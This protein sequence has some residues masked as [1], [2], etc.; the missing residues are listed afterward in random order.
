M[1]HEDTQKPTSRHKDNINKW[2]Y[3]VFCDI[4][5]RVLL[6]PRFDH[7][8]I[9]GISARGKVFRINTT[10]RVVNVVFELISSMQSMEF[11]CSESRFR[12]ENKYVGLRSGN[13][14]IF[15]AL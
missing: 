5:K 13:L 14:I 3:G 15:A 2:N 4:N 8:I 11:Y 9:L 12:S 1:K 6:L 10:M 7:M